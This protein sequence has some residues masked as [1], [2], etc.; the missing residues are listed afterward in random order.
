MTCFDLMFSVLLATGLCAATTAADPPRIFF[1]DLESGP[2]TGGEKNDGAFVSI[3]GAGFGASRDSS[4]VRTGGGAAAHYPIWTDNRITFQLGRA[5]ATGEI[6]V[7]TAR[8][9]SNAVP[10]TV[11][12]GNIYFVATTGN[13]GNNGAFA[14]PWRT[15]LKARDALQPGDIAYALNGVSQT[16]D[17]GQGWS[18]AMMLR[19]GGAPGRPKALVAYPGAVVTIGSITGPAHGVR[20]TDFSAGGGACPGHWVFAGIVFR[21]GGA[22]TLAGPSS[23]W[24]IVANDFS[25]PNGDGAGACFDTSQASNVQFLGN[26][27]HHAGKA[28]ASALYH[29]VYFSTDSNH[30]GAG[31]NTI[32]YVRGC[33]GLQVHS[34]P[35]MAG[36]GYNQ[37]DIAIHDN[38][39]HDTQC[40]GI[41]LAT[42]DPSK[43]KVEVFNN[44]IYNAG[45][46][47]NN[48]EHSGHWACIL[49]AGSTNAGAPGGGVIEV[50]N[51]TLYACGTFATPPYASS[52]SAVSNGG[53]N[54]N[55]RI[56]LRNNII[57]QTG[58]APYL[59]VWGPTG[60]CGV[61]SNCTGI[62]GSNNLFFGSG[63]APQNSNLVRSLS[64][65][66]LFV[67]PEQHDFHL[68][69]DS[70]ARG[71]GVDTGAANNKDG[72]GR[73]GAGGSDLGALPYV[74]PAPAPK[75]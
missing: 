31:W 9:K 66:P 45:Q 72:V 74:S 38:T 54:Q 59:T 70:P 46:G 44:I 2:A 40:D 10:F 17:D 69:S 18:A 24:R 7:I 19:T 67:S 39:I 28:G 68:R 41:V 36:T 43:G 50:Y 63:P 21:G 58:G 62:G 61:F 47:P 13:D 26:T 75:L 30:I 15:L 5:A 25:C 29:G 6:V 57:Y 3:Y 71:A 33:R 42:V 73:G 64:S 34:S 8:G 20:S 22:M 4:L 27:V 12:P 60:L 56:R 65:N 16:T 52:R 49:A 32:E 48:P 55:L 37:Y 1:S 51:N 11:R 53:H 35:V 14:S 23:N